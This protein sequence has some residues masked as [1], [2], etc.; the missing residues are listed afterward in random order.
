MKVSEMIEKL[1]Q[2]KS[3]H[4]DL[5]VYNSEGAMFF[6]CDSEYRPRVSKFYYGKWEDFNDYMKDELLEGDIEIPDKE[7]Y[8]VDLTK[9]ITL[10]VLI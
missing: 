7:L 3:E 2:I 5:E 10:G 4:G 1:Q 6:K 8:D 9:P